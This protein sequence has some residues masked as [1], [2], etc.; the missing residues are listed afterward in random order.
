MRILQSSGNIKEVRSTLASFIE[1]HL[2]VRANVATTRG[3]DRSPDLSSIA[4][5]EDVWR[6]SKVTAVLPLRLGGASTDLFVL[7]ISPVKAQN[8]EE[9]SED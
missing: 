6:D 3:L 1:S 2:A 8:T 5:I 9:E 7:A 4:H